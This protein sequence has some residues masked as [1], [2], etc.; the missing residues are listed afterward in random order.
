MCQVTHRA[1]KGKPHKRGLIFAGKASSAGWGEGWKLLCVCVCVFVICPHLKR[2][3][4]AVL[5]LRANFYPHK[6]F[7]KV[8]LQKINNAY[9]ISVLAIE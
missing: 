1:R 7:V 3:I 5:G 4:A 9:I 8:H 2:V 6:E